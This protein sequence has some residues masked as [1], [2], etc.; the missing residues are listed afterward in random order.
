MIKYKHN[1]SKNI[2]RVT[3]R[4]SDGA[5]LILDAYSANPPR[6]MTR[7]ET[8]ENLTLNYTELDVTKYATK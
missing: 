5:Y 3:K 4:L 6:G 2:F 7:F 1:R 8:K